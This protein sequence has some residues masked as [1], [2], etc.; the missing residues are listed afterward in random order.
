[1]P[2]ICQV[3][4][5]EY[6]AKRSDSKTCSATCRDRK[7]RGVALVVDSIYLADF[8]HPLVTATRLEREAAGKVDSMLG[9]QALTLAKQLSKSST[10]GLASLS[11]ELR[12]I[13]VAL[14]GSQAN[15]GAGDLIDELRARR[16]A[17]RLF[18]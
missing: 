13:M 11:R 12:A 4:G 9:Q 18:R 1:M 8:E 15:A 14:V 17:K 2:P 6:E 3:C 10:M 5:R 7:R 16:D